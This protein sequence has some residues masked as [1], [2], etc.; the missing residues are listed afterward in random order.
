MYLRFLPQKTPIMPLENELF[1]S[2]EIKDYWNMRGTWNCNQDIKWIIAHSSETKAWEKELMVWKNVYSGILP[3]FSNCWSMTGGASTPS[4]ST[5][6]RRSSS[7][8]TDNVL[9]VT[10]ASVNDSLQINHFKSFGCIQ[11]IG[12]KGKKSAQLLL[13]T[14]P[15]SNLCSPGWVVLCRT[16]QGDRPSQSP[17]GPSRRPPQTCALS[18]KYSGHQW[19]LFKT[20]CSLQYL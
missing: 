11:F 2:W 15:R 9:W 1:F 10:L 18:L 4:R 12:F 17:G 7:K 20:W 16:P 14:V 19:C 3:Y 5:S 13:V 8:S 6:S